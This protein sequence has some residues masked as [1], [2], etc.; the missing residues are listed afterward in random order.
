MSAGPRGATDTSIS[1]ARDGR[2]SGLRWLLA[3]VAARDLSALVIPG[4]EVARAAG[5]DLQAAGLSRAAGPR[6]ANVLAVMVPHTGLPEALERAAEVAYSQMPRPRAVLIVGS[7]DLASLPV[8]TRCEQDQDS[9]AEAVG[10]LRRAFAEGAFAEGTEDFEAPALETRTVYTCSMHPEIEQN[11][12][13]SCP[14]C[15]MDLVPKES[16]S[17][18]AGTDHVHGGHEHGAH[19]HEGHAQEEQTG[20][21]GAH[22]DQA[23]GGAHDGRHED[24]EDGES[25]ESHGG[26]DHSEHGDMDFMSMVEMTQGTPRSSDGLQMEWVDAPFGPLLPGLPGG[27]SL[28]LTLD[29]DT[30]AQAQASVQTSSTEK[31]LHG[32]ASGL[33]GRLSG[34]DPLSPFSYGLL[35]TLALED[36]AGATTSGNERL[37]RIATLELER[38]ASHSGWLSGFATLLGLDLLGREAARLEL[39]LRRLLAEPLDQESNDRDFQSSAASLSHSLNRSRLLRSRLRGVGVLERRHLAGVRGPIARSAGHARDQ[40]AEDADYG[41]L[42]FEPV[43]ENSSDALARLRLRAAE[44]KQSLQIAREAMR[45]SAN[46]GRPPEATQVVDSG[47]GRASVETPRGAAALSLRIDD[48]EVSEAQLE[49]PSAVALELAENLAGDQELGDALAGVA[50]LDISPWGLG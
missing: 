25:H 6:Q 32:P 11:E 23:G 17:G 36:A 27:L 40:R 24:A 39:S 5:L 41:A 45:G 22:D 47:S 3:R 21:S 29:G 20:H 10:G 2:F 13:G 48:G 9:L 12:P 43:L 31:I 46:S 16:T 38:A 33:A 7:G 30:V 18:E 34:L 50:S 26:H 19:D 1:G 44:M 4:P 28:S 15:G 42:G 14:K 49:L 8:D 35:A 37:R